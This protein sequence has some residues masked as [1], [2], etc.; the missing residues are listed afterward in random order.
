ME[1]LQNGSSVSDI[2][3]LHHLDFNKASG[4]KAKWEW[5]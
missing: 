5:H 1:I 2:V 4:E 3:W